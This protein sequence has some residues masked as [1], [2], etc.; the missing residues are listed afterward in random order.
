VKKNG[1]SIVLV[2]GF[3]LANPCG[4]ATLHVDLAGTAPV[5][6]Y[7]NWA[8]AATNIQDAVDAAS[9]NDVVLVTNGLYRLVSEIYIAK[10]I[11]IQSV[12]GAAATLVDGG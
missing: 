1:G 8:T 9:S 11:E 3:L 4:A 12:N 10:E 5:P 7:S 6:P 2:A